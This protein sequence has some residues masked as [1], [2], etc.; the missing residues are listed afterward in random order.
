MNRSRKLLVG[1]FCV[2]AILLALLPG[3]DVLAEPS[4]WLSRYSP[5]IAILTLTLVAVIFYAAFTFELVEETREMVDYVGSQTELLR[6][7][8][9]YD[10]KRLRREHLEHRALQLDKCE[11]VVGLLGES[12]RL[13]ESLNDSDLWENLYDGPDAFTNQYGDNLLHQRVSKWKEDL[14]GKIRP[15]ASEIGP[16]LELPVFVFAGEALGLAD[17]LGDVAVGSIEPQDAEDLEKKLK[18]DFDTVSSELDEA[19]EESREYYFGLMREA[20]GLDLLGLD[21]EQRSPEPGPESV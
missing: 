20:E 6:R 7:Q 3:W 5:S 15:L 4:Q 10:Q 19:I 11:E 13:L 14:V 9:K 17:S 21:D 12:R 16:P 8:V 18:G 1:F 2:G